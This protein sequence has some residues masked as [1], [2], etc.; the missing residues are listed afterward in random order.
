[1]EAYT[2]KEAAEI[3]GI[4]ENALRFYEKKKLLHPKRLENGYRQYDAL[5]LTKAQMIILYRKFHFSIDAIDTMMNSEDTALDIFVKQYYTISKTLRLCKQMQSSLLEC[6]NSLLMEEQTDCVSYMRDVLLES[7]DWEDEWNFDE[8]AK[9]YD[10][11]I[12]KP[13]KGLP[14]YKH[15]DE[16]L[17][18]CVKELPLHGVIADI[19]IGTGNLTKCIMDYYPKARVIGVEPSLSM[20]RI[21]KKKLP[22][23]PLRLGHFLELPFS[24]HEV[25]VIVSSYA[26]HHCH[27]EDQRQ[28]IREMSRVL[29]ENGTCIIADVMFEDKDAK[30][31]YGRKCMPL[32]RE[33]LY[34][35]HFALLSDIEQ[36][37]LQEGFNCVK[38]QIDEL[39]WIIIAKKVKNNE[40]ATK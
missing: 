9:T 5:E 8:W 14:F 38:K 1:M 6:I 4:S 25:D 2:I 16:V 12:H 40:I 7:R 15:Y 33:E 11:S 37:F 34:N 17:S 36:Y 10:E 39:L 18:S 22:E 26:F 35:E 28:A 19:G 31:N 23:V 24:D 27:K 29:R 21:C 3:L 20:C 30:E 13:A 32:Q